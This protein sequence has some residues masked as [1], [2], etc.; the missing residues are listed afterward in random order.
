MT[1]LTA[2]ADRWSAE[3]GDLRARV[4]A[5]APGRAL[6]GHVNQDADVAIVGVSG[7]GTVTVDGTARPVGPSTL[8]LVPKGAHR[9]LAA[10]PGEEFRVLVVHRRTAVTGPFRWRPRRR[11]PW[12]DDPWEDERE[13]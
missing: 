2:M 1:D 10:G 12:E 4:V 8:V 5:L 13:G 9:E 6:A 7:R 3:A 11:R